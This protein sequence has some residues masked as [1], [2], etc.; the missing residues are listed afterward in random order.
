M[1]QNAADWHERFSLQAGWTA[2][3]RHYLFNLAGLPQSPLIL[4]VGC[5]T[6][7]LTS[8]AAQ[9]DTWH[10]VGI[11]ISSSFISYAA[12]RVPAAEFLTSDGGNLPFVKSSFD[13]SFCHYVLMWLQDPLSV[14]REMK[15]VTKP[16]SAI[17]VLA[18][19]DYGGRIDFPPRLEE[20][21]RWQVAA[22][23]HQGADPFIGRKLSSLFHKLDLKEIE[24]GVIGAQWR[25]APSEAEI[26][27][28]W[29]VNLHDFEVVEK[30]NPELSIDSES[31]K[32]LDFQAW[33]RG[34][35]ILY[36]PTFYALG[37]V[38]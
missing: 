26:Q 11:D 38:P 27:S 19:P 2:G 18:E 3:V 31:L 6:G 30:E 37:R 12:A 29:R 9:M 10:A 25:T 32:D 16:G 28:E 1:L 8:Q 14:L 22:L 35:R 21:A 4:D 34:E 36:V 24:I 23:I 15:R 33:S 13:C 5:G 7:A 17:L 20:I